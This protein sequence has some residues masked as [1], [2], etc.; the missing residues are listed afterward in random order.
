MKM[1]R[2][3]SMALALC[4]VF[5]SAAALPEGTFITQSTSI[6]VSAEG[7]IVSGDYSYVEL[8]DGTIEITGYSGTETE[9]TVPTT[10]D[11]KTVTSIGDFA[12]SN[13]NLT[14]VTLPSTI[15]NIGNNAFRQCEKLESINLPEGLLT[16]GDS[17]FYCCEK[18]ET[19][20][21]PS[22]VTSIGKSAFFQCGSLKSVE[23]PS[24]ITEIPE[25]A[26]RCCSALESITIPSG[27][28]SIGADAFSGCSGAKTITI[29]DTVTNID[30][31]AF[32]DCWAVESITIPGSVTTLGDSAFYECKALTSLT[33]E[34]GDMGFE[35][36]GYQAFYKCEKLTDVTIPG[37]VKTIGNQA[38]MGCSSITTLTLEEGIEMLDNWCFGDCTSLKSVTI[39]KSVKN[40]MSWAFPSPK[41]G[42]SLKIL[43]YNDTA[44]EDYAKIGK[45]EYELLDIE[46]VAAVA[47]TCTTAGNI[48][49]WTCGDKFYSDAVADTEIEQKDTV[50]A[51][52]GHKFPGK[53][54]VDKP[55]SVATPGKKSITC[56]V[57]GG[58]L[59][60]GVETK[61]IPKLT[62]DRASGTNRFETSQMIA[63]KIREENSYANFE[64]IIIASGADFADALSASY[65]AKVKKAPILL[66]ASKAKD[67]LSSTV[68]YV[69]KNAVAKAN[70]Y[71]VGGTSAVPDSLASDLKKAGCTVKR[72]SGPNRFDTNIAVLKEAGVSK[73]QILIAS[74]TDYADA[75]SA[76]AV[77]KPILLVAGK[78][79]SLTPNQKAYLNSLKSANSAALSKAYIIGGTG[80]VSK[81]IADQ[82]KGMF[83][84]T[85]R[86]S[87]KNRYETSIEVA[88]KFFKDP[89]TLT[90][91]YGLNYP[92]GLCGGPLAMAYNSPLILTVSTMTTVA[93]E[94]AKSVKAESAIALGGTTLISDADI[95]AIIGK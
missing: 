17:A 85:V 31:Y 79:N 9:V 16:I 74:G 69:K 95:K 84:S 2:V 56:T 44:G 49:Y 54:T 66:V 91:A 47:A 33:F 23:I 14:K 78:T 26:F 22:T 24:G 40:V 19:A 76:S 82:V 11:E 64:N 55:A 46:H 57:C 12:F 38:F 63:K 60:G 10:I 51:A 86:V 7:E 13:P 75:L 73:E 42:Y 77:G 94:Y 92:D 39:P 59:E 87:G 20:D 50:I 1:K 18:L 67:V 27:V 4:M 93:A 29:P 52:K 37:T 6:T 30:G 58:E 41:D 5:G 48:E 36:I 81:G 61:E 80:A 8:G 62:K 28:T 89:K 21:I 71:I 45:Y 65:L 25:S 53:W 68:D 70:V 83:K 90:L 3:L 88:K 15:T 43:C 34:K 32:A 72:I 35:T